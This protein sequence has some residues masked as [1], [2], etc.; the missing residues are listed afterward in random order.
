MARKQK[1]RENIQSRHRTFASIMNRANKRSS[2][3]QFMPDSMTTW[4]TTLW[5]ML[6]TRV[7]HLGPSSTGCNA[8][9]LHCCDRESTPCCKRRVSCG[10]SWR[11]TSVEG[12]RRRRTMRDIKV[13]CWEMTDLQLH[14]AGG[15][16]S[17]LL[18]KSIAFGFKRRCLGLEPQRLRFSRLRRWMQARR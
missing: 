1:K 5:R 4:T 8:A 17:V 7:T 11:E 2:R 12:C 9:R 13:R 6:Q 16:A 15:Q 18:P 10:R 14:D 3:F